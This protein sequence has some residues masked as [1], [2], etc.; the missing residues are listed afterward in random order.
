MFGMALSLTAT[1]LATSN[2]SIHSGNS[3]GGWDTAGVSGVM[4]A[5]DCGSMEIVTRMVRSASSGNID[6]SGGENLDGNSRV[7]VP[8]HVW[9]TRTVRDA[10]DRFKGLQ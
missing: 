9:G 5:E 7:R 3:G 6:L 2:G 8:S 4:A 10:L 1:R